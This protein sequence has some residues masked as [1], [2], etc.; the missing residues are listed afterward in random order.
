MEQPGVQALRT[1][2]AGMP[3]QKLRDDLLPHLLPC[4]RV[5]EKA[6]H[7]D[8]QFLEQELRLLGVL[9]EKLD[10]G[11]DPVDLVEAHAPLDPAVDGALLVQGKVLTG[12]G[13]QEDEDL[14]QGALGFLLQGAS[15]PGDERGVLQVGDDPAGE[16]L[17]RG[18]DV[19]Q[20]RVDGAPGHAVEFGRLRRLDEDHPGLFL[21]RPKAQRTVG[22]H[23]REDDADALVLSVVRQGAEEEIDRQAEP[24]GGRRVEQVQYTVEDGH[25]LVGGDHVDLVRRDLHAVPDLDDLHGGGALEELHHDPLVGGVEV[26]DDDEGDAASRGHVL[27]E[28]L[29]RLEAAGG[30]ADADDG[31][32]AVRVAAVHLRGCRFHRGGL[33]CCF[34]SARGCGSFFHGSALPSQSD[35]RLIGNATRQPRP[36]GGSFIKRLD[37]LAAL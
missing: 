28:E 19:G 27:Q 24:P 37:R 16:L 34:T 7:A 25:V 1:P 11:R 32:C 22:A 30:G 14:L 26:L 21:D 31:K 12:L 5:A 18:H 4:R 8:E 6:G 35:I 29:Q 10:V 2:P 15:G 36:V 20:A 3:R 17:R 13:P 23:P 33:G 9:L